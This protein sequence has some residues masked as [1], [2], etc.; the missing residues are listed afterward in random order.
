VQRNGIVVL[1]SVAL[2]SVA[3]IV[4]AYFFT[5]KPEPEP[6]SVEQRIEQEQAAKIAC[7][8]GGGTWTPGDLGGSICEQS[9][10]TQAGPV[11]ASPSPVAPATNGGT[12]CF[13]QITIGDCVAAKNVRKQVYKNTGY[14]LPTSTDQIVIHSR[15]ACQVLGAS[16]TNARFLGVAQAAAQSLG[17]PL[18]VGLQFVGA[19]FAYFC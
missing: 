9:E 10:P 13:G 5:H 6:G 4:A 12:G 15:A 3:G 8:E 1:F 19:S 16:P 14:Q 11:V 18:Q 2:L 17:I 7:L